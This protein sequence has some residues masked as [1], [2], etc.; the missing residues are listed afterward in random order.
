MSFA[1]VNFFGGQGY[2]F[3]PLALIYSG[4]ALVLI[5]RWAATA[6]R[7]A[8]LAAATTFGLAIGCL[9]GHVTS[10]PADSTLAEPL[11]LSVALAAER[12][13]LHRQNLAAYIDRNLPNIP[14][15]L[16]A[17]CRE[18]QDAL[19][20][21]GLLC[22]DVEPE[23]LDAAPAASDQR[24]HELWHKYRSAKDD[25]ELLIGQHQPTP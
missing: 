3:W 7:P 9:L 22:V 4:A 19:A 25:L 24:G 8:V 5:S 21:R 1:A 2:A 18:I 13:D 6:T 12:V 20:E 11:E 16:H 17:N 14:E 23:A 10:E 15:V